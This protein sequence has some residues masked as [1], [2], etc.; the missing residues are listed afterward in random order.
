MSKVPAGAGPADVFRLAPGFRSGAAACGLKTSGALDLALIVAGAPAAAAGVFTTNLVQAAPVLFD[1]AALARPGARF[2]AV[3]ANS[4]CANACTGERGLADAAATASQTGFALGCAPEEVLVLSTGVIGVPL[5]LEKVTRG[6]RA[7]AARLGEDATD[8]T[9]A[10]MTTDTRPKTAQGEVRLPGGRAVVRGFAKGAGMIH[11]NMATMFAVLT[12]DATAPPALLA[13]AL[14]GAAEE[15]F[16]RISVDG[17]M[18]TNDTVLLLASGTSGVE[19]RDADEP[20]FTAALAGVCVAL[21]RQIVRDG[22]GATRLVEIAVRG[23]ADVGQARVVADGI[24][25]SSLVKTAIHGG[26]PNWGRI[27][28][29]AGSCGAAIDPGRLR[30]A[31]GL[32]GREVWVVLGGSRADYDERAAASLLAL[33]PVHI[34]LDLGLGDA[35]CVVWT[36]DLSAEYVA[37]NAHYTT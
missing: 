3:V 2:R 26:D 30:L 36:C 35:C 19:V 29:A 6:I 22:E 15:S 25:R 5:D 18:S 20:S 8:V 10:V 4:G 7:A 28:A 32:P 11:P 16:N 34:G 12:T 17:D 23:A 33:D 27:L 21:A 37:I 31:F 24:A 9:R 13:R 1:R 14:R